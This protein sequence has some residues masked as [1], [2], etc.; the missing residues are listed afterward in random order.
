MKCFAQYCNSHLCFKVWEQ[1]EEFIPERFDLEGPV[2][3]ESNTDFR[4]TFYLCVKTTLLIVLLSTIDTY[5]LP[6]KQPIQSPCYKSCLTSNQSPSLR[7]ATNTH[8]K[9]LKWW[10]LNLQ[11]VLICLML[12]PHPSSDG[13]HLSVCKVISDRHF[14]SFLHIS[15]LEILCPSSLLTVSEPGHPIIKVAIL[16]P[17]SLSSFL[18]PS[19][20]HLFNLFTDDEF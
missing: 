6:G 5:Q 8:A 7:K 17:L 14:L 2:P 10:H 13:C 3:N 9:M 11:A 19:Q 16:F 18:H 15:F 12:S 20:F 4:Y 1:A